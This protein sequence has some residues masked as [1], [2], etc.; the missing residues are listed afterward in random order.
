LTR[1]T[2]V[3]FSTLQ[4]PPHAWRGLSPG[5]WTCLGLLAIPLWATWPA[6][7][8]RS[9]AIPA[10]ECLTLAFA[11]G[12]LVLARLE[13]TARLRPKGAPA[14]T[15]W[16]DWL[17]ACA[18][19]L[20]LTGSNAFHILATHFIPAAEANLISYLWP[21]EIIGLG[22]ALRLFRLERRHLAGLGLGIAGA[23]ALMGR[24]GSG[25]SP[26]GIT[27]ALASGLSWA[28]FCLFRLYWQGA[29]P[30]VLQRGCALSMLL[31]LLLHLA[32]EPTVV[33]EPGALAAAAA[34]GIVPLALGNLAWDQGL[35]RGDAR[36]LTVMAY[37]TPLCSAVLLVG[38]GL[39][40]PG[41]S[42]GVGATLIVIAGWLSHT[43]R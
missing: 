10:F 8:L 34:V 9:L 30:R 23:L 17:P 13:S 41:L 15:A 20:G 39:E 2:A 24:G 33:P 1:S 6:L 32:F 28:L 3:C 7:A 29:S 38:L 21:V 4:S 25:L 43:A 5:A 40:S 42:L 35:R 26:A 19:A 18:C 16:R 37:A 11:T 36:L 31:C 14:P 27:L 22:A 12:T